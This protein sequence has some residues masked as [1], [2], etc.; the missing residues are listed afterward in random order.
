MCSTYNLVNL[1]ISDKSQTDSGID[2]SF[3]QDTA[4]D[5]LHAATSNKVQDH[6][7][8]LN[9][10]VVESGDIGLQDNNTGSKFIRSSIQQVASDSG[11]KTSD[12]QQLPAVSSE[13][14]S[15]RD[16]IRGARLLQDP[17]PTDGTVSQGDTCSS[18]CPDSCGAG[19]KCDGS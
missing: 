5:V 17:C 16:S 2:S 15:E 12:G 3:D 10:K 8:V 1:L 6:Q 11:G 14:K 9:N 7:A 13:L 4:V 18:E 19:L